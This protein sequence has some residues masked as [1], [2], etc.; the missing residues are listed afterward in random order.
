MSTVYQLVEN[1]KQY[2]EIKSISSEGGANNMQI[3]K[4]RREN[5]VQKMS[6]VI[7]RKVARLIS[8]RKVY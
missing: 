8:G 1:I 6:T 4:L 5:I 3:L 7:I 2:A